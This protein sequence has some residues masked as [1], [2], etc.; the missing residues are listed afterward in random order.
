MSNKLNVWIGVIRLRTLPLAFSSIFL[1]SFLAA[2]Y[3]SF[4]WRIGILSALTAIFLQIL[5][6]MANDLGDGL[7][8]TDNEYRV[9]PK[10]AIQ[11]K[12]LS[13]REITVGIGLFVVLSLVSGIWL[14]SLGIREKRS[15][16]IIFFILLGI[17]AIASA[18]KYTIGSKPYGYAGLGDL[19]VFFWFGIVGVMGTFFLHTNFMKIDVLLPSTSLGLLCVSVLNINN[20]RD[21]VSDKKA[22]KKTFVV[23]IGEFHAKIYQAILVSLAIATSLIFVILHYTA[24][25][26]LL[27][28]LTI[29]FLLLSVKDVIRITEPKLFDPYLKRF[30]FGAFIFAIVFGLGLILGGY[31]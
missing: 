18:I 31:A 20:L 24:I 21:R 9:G 23:R 14:I 8:G 5:S 6:N 1:G 3:G 15:V 19:F 4:R 16:Y 10:R 2:F 29:P 30:A 12:L 28:L 27:F 17:A 11:N 26:Q 25:I 13:K 22:G 7:K